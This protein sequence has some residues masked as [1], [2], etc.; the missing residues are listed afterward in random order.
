MEANLNALIIATKA[1]ASAMEANLNPR[2]AATEPDLNTQIAA[3]EVDL[4]M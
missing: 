3:E 1:A 2:M 4:H